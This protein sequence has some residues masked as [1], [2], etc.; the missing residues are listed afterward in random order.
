MNNRDRANNAIIFIDELDT[1]DKKQGKGRLGNDEMGYCCLGIGCKVLETKN[2]D[3][4][5]GSSHELA[6]MSGL[7]SSFGSYIKL[8]GNATNDRVTGREGLVCLNDGLKYTFKQ[9]AERLR[10]HP[11]RYFKGTVGAMIAKHYRDAA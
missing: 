8:D 9:I 7:Y 6:E 4:N 11:R 5:Q 3:P 2:Y 1:T 10:T